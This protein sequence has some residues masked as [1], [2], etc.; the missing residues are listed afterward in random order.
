MEIL[1]IL[2]ANDIGMNNMIDL[3]SNPAA[4]QQVQAIVRRAAAQQAPAGYAP[5]PAP[6]HRHHRRHH[7]L[8]PSSPHGNHRR[9]PSSPRRHRKS[10]SLRVCRSWRHCA[11]PVRLRRGVHREAGPDTFRSLT[12]SVY[13]EGRNHDVHGTHDRALE[14]QG[15]PPDTDRDG[16]R[17]DDRVGRVPA[18]ARFGTETGVLGAIIAW[19]SR[20]SECSCSPSSSSVWRCASPT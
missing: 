10:P 11:R 9:L 18:A 12:R 5:A 8:P 19:T 16:G 7:H 14:R 13:P 4:R 1:Q 3:R 15:Q 6:A 17:L 2:K 20:A